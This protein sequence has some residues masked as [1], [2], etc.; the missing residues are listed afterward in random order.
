MTIGLTVFFFTTFGALGVTIICLD[1]VFRKLSK[2]YPKYY[3]KIGRP[4]ALYR[5]IYEPIPPETI[6]I[7][8]TVINSMQFILSLAFRGTPKDFPKNSSLRKLLTIA[9]YSWIY[10]GAG[11]LSWLVLAYFLYP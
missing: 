6:G 11:S 5:E 4:I 7:S 1:V 10:A 8:N 2:S 3:T 9:R